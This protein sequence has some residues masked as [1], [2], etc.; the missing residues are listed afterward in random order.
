[1]TA[2]FLWEVNAKKI[3]KMQFSISLLVTM[4]RYVHLVLR[5]S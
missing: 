1:M 2:L 3:L 5:D 4:R